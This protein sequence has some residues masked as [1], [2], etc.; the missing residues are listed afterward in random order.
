MSRW[1]NFF[2]VGAP[3]AATSSLYVH[4]R[5][6]PDIFMPAVKEPH[7]FA[8][9]ESGG[10]AETP[11]VRTYAQFRREEDYLR[12]FEAAGPE[13]AVGEASTGYLYDDQAPRRIH[14]RVPEAKIII[15]LRDPI[16]RAYS[17]YSKNLVEIERGPFFEALIEDSARPRKVIGGARLYSEFGLYYEGVRRYLDTFAREDLHLPVRG[18]RGRPCEGCRRHMC[19]PGGAVSWWPFL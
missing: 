17:Q 4:L 2:I 19:I 11:R 16:E 10:E 15:S 12:L 1:P 5:G 18:L 3:R 6:H 13:R 8:Q 14:E 9:V 7:F